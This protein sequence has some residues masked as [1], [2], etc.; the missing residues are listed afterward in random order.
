MKSVGL[1]VGSFGGYQ[2]VNVSLSCDGDFIYESIMLLSINWW[3]ET[4]VALT[5]DSYHG[6]TVKKN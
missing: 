1:R 2:T 6:K 3:I 4:S 5:I